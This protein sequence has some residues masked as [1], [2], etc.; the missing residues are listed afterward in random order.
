MVDVTTTHCIITHKSVDLSFL[1][2]SHPPTSYNQKLISSCLTK[3][4]NHEHIFQTMH[5]EYSLHSNSEA[6]ISSS[7]TELMALKMLYREVK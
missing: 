2:V 4:L 3:T 1:F 6:C 5:K 7:T